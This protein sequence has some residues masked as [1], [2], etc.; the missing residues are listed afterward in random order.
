MGHVGATLTSSGCKESLRFF[1]GKPAGT[2][3][4][5]VVFKTRLDGALGNLT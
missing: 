1:L 5:E 2:S 3:S 4:A